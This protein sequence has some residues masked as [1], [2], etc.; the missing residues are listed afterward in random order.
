MQENSGEERRR[1]PRYETD[2]KIQFYV[3]FNLK[4]V[5]E[6]RIKEEGAEDFSEEKYTG[7]TKNVSVE[8]LCLSSRINLN[9]GDALY[10]E[11]FVPQSKAPIIMEGRVQWCRAAEGDQKEEGIEDF[12]DAGIKVV[13]VNG[14]FV[15]QTIFFDEVHK[16]LWSSVL[17]TVFS[18]FKELSKVRLERLRSVSQQSNL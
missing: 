12:Y 7:I 9:K 15:E 6:Y 16:M 11:V 17:E 4:T 5:V 1:S 2:V 18:S 14:E 3:N 8:G 13:S 10:M